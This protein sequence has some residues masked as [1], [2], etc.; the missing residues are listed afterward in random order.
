MKILGAAVNWND[1]WDNRPQLVIAVEE[2]PKDEEFSYASKPLTSGSVLYR[3]EHDG[4]VRFYLHNP[5]DEQGFGGRTFE[6]RDHLGDTFKIKGP[7]SSRASVINRYFQ[8]HCTEVV[9]TTN[10]NDLERN[11][12][13]GAPMYGGAVTLDT[14]IEAVKMT[15]NWLARI[16]EGP[17]AEISYEPVMRWSVP[18][19]IMTKIVG[20]P[21][22]YAW[23]FVHPDIWSTQGFENYQHP[24]NEIGYQPDVTM[25]MARDPITEDPPGVE[26]EPLDPHR[27]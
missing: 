23:E 9:F 7:W 6:L 12:L 26:T 10:P 27:R 17:S 21:I 16:V 18:K 11:S 3:A 14:A 19:R 1:K 25:K 20:G 24:I 5:H 22:G 4:F 2:L 13:R 15:G 8:P